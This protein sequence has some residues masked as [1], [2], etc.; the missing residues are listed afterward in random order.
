MKTIKERAKEYRKDTEESVFKSGMDMST[1]ELEYAYKRG[2]ID[3]R[4]FDIK[5]T[6]EWMNANWRNYIDTDADG[7]IRFSGWQNDFKK[8]MMNE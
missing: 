4:Y 2:A 7:M 1:T 5:K 8:A 3:Q 6:S